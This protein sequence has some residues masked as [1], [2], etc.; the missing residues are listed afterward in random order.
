MTPVLVNSHLIPPAER[1]V[2]HLSSVDRLGWNPSSTLHY[3]RTLPAWMSLSVPQF[4]LLLK[5]NQQYL[6]PRVE[7][8][9]L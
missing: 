7:V 5:G 2:Y 8:E 1:A 6:L 3:Q 4:L 9:L